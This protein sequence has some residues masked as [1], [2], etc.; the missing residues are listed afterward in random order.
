MRRH[1]SNFPYIGE[2]V[3]KPP[4]SGIKKTKRLFPLKRYMNIIDTKQSLVADLTV[5]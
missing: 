2:H 1:S 3:K 4:S 5:S